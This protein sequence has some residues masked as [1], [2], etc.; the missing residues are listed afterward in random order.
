MN[1]A[2]TF[3]FLI[4]RIKQIDFNDV[5]I[6]TYFFEKQIEYYFK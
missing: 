4:N 1:K 5:K 6:K 2:T 3:D